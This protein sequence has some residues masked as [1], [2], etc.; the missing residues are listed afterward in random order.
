MKKGFTLAEVLITLGIIGVVAAMTIPTLIQNTNSIKFVTQFKKDISTLSQAALMAQAQYDVD[1][2][3]LDKTPAEITGTGCG[4]Q[5]LGKSNISMCGLFNATLAGQTF[6][7]KLS[8]I[9][10]ADAAA[11]SYKTAVEAGHKTT[12]WY[13][14]DFLVFALADGSLVGF[15]N[16]AKDCSLATGAVISTSTLTASSGGLKKCLGFVDV[17]GVKTPNKEVT[18]SDKTAVLG[19]VNSSG[20]ETTCNLTDRGSEIGDIYPIVF[21]DGTVEPATNAAKAAITRGKS[22]A[23]TN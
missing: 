7:G 23:A 14:N 20:G 16:D 11:G 22:S 10:G 4:S 17:N 19:S 13:G 21:H 2:A 1:Y 9:K 6:Q 15:S 5:H 18:C 12:G 8:E 3:A